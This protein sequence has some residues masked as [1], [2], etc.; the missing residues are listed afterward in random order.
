MLKKSLKNFLKCEGIANPDVIVRRGE[1]HHTCKSNIDLV[2]CHQIVQQ[3]RDYI[4]LLENE[5]GLLTPDQKEACELCLS[6]C[7]RFIYKEHLDTKATEIFAHHGWSLQ[8]DGTVPL[9]VFISGPRRLGKTRL[10]SVIIAA[11]LLAVPGVVVLGLAAEPGPAVMLC[12]EVVDKVKILITLTKR[13]K[14][15]RSSIEHF[16]VKVGD[17]TSKMHVFSARKHDG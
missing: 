17:D 11:I 15:I 13:G 8:Q 3:T 4:A 6:S 1:F 7:S 5:I 14:I 16:Y 12:E 10:F 2:R 9:G